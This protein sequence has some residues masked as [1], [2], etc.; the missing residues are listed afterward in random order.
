MARF[1]RSRRG[2]YA[3][4]L[5]VQL[6]V[7]PLIVHDW[8]GFV[9]RRAAEDL[10]EGRTPYAVAEEDPSY[11]HLG[12][13][14]PP[15]NTWYAYPPLAL[16]LIVL[17]TAPL[18]P[19]SVDPMWMRVAVKLSFIV[20]HLALAFVAGRVA[21]RLAG[22]EEGALARK[23]TEDLVL[24]NPFLVFIAA[25]WGMFDGAM[26]AFLLGSLWLLSTG[27]PALAGASFGGAVLMKLFPL[28]VAPLFLG[29][30]WRRLGG[31]AAA[32]FVAA[33]V[34]AF[35]VVCLPFVL[36]TPEG[37]FLQT[38]GLH[39]DRGI[40][41][42]A[43]VSAP[44]HVGWLADLVGLSLPVPSERSLGA[45]SSVLLVATFVL[46]CVR[47]TSVKDEGA[48]VKASL[49][50]L[51]LVLLVSKVVNEQY[52]VMPIAL[53]AVL[54]GSRSAST[55]QAPL[56]AFTWG[57][58]V[59][60][61]LLGLHFITFFPPDVAA[62]LPLDPAY[63]FHELLR[64]LGVSPFSAT[65]AIHLV[66]MLALVPA[67]VHSLRI[68]RDGSRHL[69]MRERGAR[70]AGRSA[71]VVVLLLL[72]SAPF[73]ATLREPSG[74]FA[75]GPEPPRHVLFEYHLALRNPSHD[76][77]VPEGSWRGHEGPP[78]LAGYYSVNSAKL[79]S[80]FAT[81]ADLG[82]TGIV[83]PVDAGNGVGPGTLLA[84]ALE[85]DLRVARR[86]DVGNLSYCPE[87]RT[88]EP[89]R[90]PRAGHPPGR[91]HEA[92][93]RECLRGIAAHLDHPAVL[94]HQGRPVVFVAGDP[95]EWSLGALRAELPG[96]M[97]VAVAPLEDGQP[98]WADGWAPRI[99]REASRWEALASSIGNATGLVVAP[100]LPPSSGG[101]GF[102]AT[103]L[104]ALRHEAAWVMLPWNDHGAGAH[105][106]PTRD[107][108]PRAVVRAAVARLSPT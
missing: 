38:V 57:A 28:F 108:D 43:L 90:L 20:G 101:G 67:L 87:A 31:R 23:R 96:A 13:R 93:L 3:L 47:G 35:A 95:P 46:A 98:S 73:L 82:A 48:V 76:P 16:L 39:A 53:L 26:M 71:L 66:A 25:G 19:F 88:V 24:F 14:W 102:E 8:D 69:R 42:F 40:Q 89:S 94:R 58:L 37:F 106:E 50:V 86:V 44:L 56:R 54:A 33:A 78:P 6:L 45:I 2:R 104:I 68:L 5:L 99:S 7:A 49:A 27:R 70:V 52:L 85:A 74:P 29:F 72:V 64:A 18:A 75:L 21:A 11:I 10:I 105:V 84:A 107:H 92:L 91:E 59:S 62:R 55:E 15:L 61:L 36:A 79:R 32:A 22:E 9:F 100:V 4:A 63:V 80:D 65:L 83:A 30:A 34:G 103:T 81:L 51:L 97:L 12:D 60:G 1:A 41:G 17:T 77:A